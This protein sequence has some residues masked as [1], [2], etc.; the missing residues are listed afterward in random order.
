M[1]ADLFTHISGVFYRSMIREHLG[2]AV[3]G[4]VRPGRYSR[5]DQPSL[6]LSATREGVEAAMIAHTA[7][8]TPD[9][10]IVPISVEA[11]HIFDLRDTIACGKA[12]IDRAKAFAEWQNLVSEGQEPESWRVADA[13]RN[14][15]ANGLIDPSRRAP[16]LWHL[17]LFR[18]NIEGG[19]RVRRL[20]EG[21]A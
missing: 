1:R 2:F 18:W 12:G 13:I 21:E 7:G 14:L 16:G 20:D 4:S 3:S 17:V 9:R 11:G 19:A 8:A 10:V 6:Y 15:G 5:A